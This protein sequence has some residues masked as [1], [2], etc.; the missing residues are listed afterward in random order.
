VWIR[1]KLGV[2]GP[3]EGASCAVLVIVAFNHFGGRA[4][5]IRGSWQ[6]SNLSVEHSSDVPDR[7]HV[8][9]P[10]FTA[11]G[12]VAHARGVVHLQLLSARVALLRGKVLVNQHDAV[13]GRKTA[14]DPLAHR[15]AVPVA[16]LALPAKVIPPKCNDVLLTDM[17]A[18]QVRL[19]EKVQDHL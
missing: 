15:G 17:F 5:Q 10:G 2:K 16:G 8:P 13:C 19:A 14:T 6:A 12:T 9:V 18:W 4:A 3:Q 1:Y 7:V 11:R